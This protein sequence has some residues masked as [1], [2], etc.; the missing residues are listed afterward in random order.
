MWVAPGCATLII[1][2]VPSNRLASSV[3]NNILHNLELLYIPI[4]VFAGPNVFISLKVFKLSVADFAI[5]DA[6]TTI[7]LGADFFNLSTFK[8][9]ILIKIKDQKHKITD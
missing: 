3:V 4:N 2:P 7:L 9:S 1:T 6:T 8:K 5:S